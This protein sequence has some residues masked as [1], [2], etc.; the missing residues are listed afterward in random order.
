MSKLS[1]AT[2]L[3]GSGTSIPSAYPSTATITAQLFSKNWLHQRDQRGYGIPLESPMIGREYW[4]K[5]GATLRLL[6][7]LRNHVD[8]HLAL[9]GENEASYEDIYYL[10]QQLLDSLQGEY[11]NP[12]LLPWLLDL[13]AKLATLDSDVDPFF[14]L[15]GSKPW[16]E[17]GPLTDLVRRCLD[18]IQESVASQLAP[19]G[20]KEGLG[21]LDELLAS[22]TSGPLNIVTLNH[23]T[24][25][26]CFLEGKTVIDGFRP[27]TT[28]ADVF[29][30]TCFDSET[31][32]EV[33]LLKLH[34]SIDWF[35]Y[36]G[37]AGRDLALRVRSGDPSHVK[38]ESGTDL[39]PP[40]QRL[41][42]AGTTN[43]ELAYGAGIF[44]ELMF[45]FHRVLKGTR[46]LVVSGYGF[47]D[48]GINN[49]IWAWLDAHPEN[50]LM[51]LHEDV[52]SLHQRAKASLAENYRRHRESKKFA[53][54]G[55]WLCNCTLDILR[56]EAKL[57]L[58]V[59]LQ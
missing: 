15:E 9:Y 11:D 13:R 23:D 18:H 41:L 28:E 24:L 39:R 22:S 32:S 58:D 56:R 12:G 21:L 51:V 38:N 37:P 7:L 6:R 25:L 33:R 8:Q 16:H 17:R 43:K 14:K 49:R 26:E 20:K 54:V 1:S 19:T 59:K 45:Q 10:G 42:L 48:K 36:Q 2:V 30:P 3:L 4:S 44:L 57:S 46:L 34:G 5:V 50:K 47:G 31:P 29:D 53:Y 55:H 52:E 27:F 35:R 40:T